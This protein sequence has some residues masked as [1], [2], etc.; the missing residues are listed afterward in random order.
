MALFR[1]SKQRNAALLE[2]IHVAAE[3]ITN[4]IPPSKRW[5]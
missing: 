4:I 3:R 2:H 5:R 1:S